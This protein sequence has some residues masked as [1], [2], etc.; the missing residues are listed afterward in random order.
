M[1]RYGSSDMDAGW[2][3]LKN[4]GR[5]GLFG[6]YLGTFG[7]YLGTKPEPRLPI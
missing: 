7:G 3:T 4:W 1:I 5:M 6:G 2:M